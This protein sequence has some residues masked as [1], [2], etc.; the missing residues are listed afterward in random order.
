MIIGLTGTIS[1]GKS[2]VAEILIKK[3][4]EHHTYSDILRLEAKKRNI[5]PTRQ[6]LQ[7]LGNKLK[8]ESK[9]EHITS[10][11]FMDYE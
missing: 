8:E 2:T 4:F 7:K 6:N 1:S 5:E 11:I 9:I 3:G 10:M